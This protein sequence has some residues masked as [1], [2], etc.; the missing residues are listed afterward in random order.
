MHAVDCTSYTMT[1][2]EMHV[3]K[4]TAVQSECYVIPTTH[5][6]RLTM[7]CL[8]VPLNHGGNDIRDSAYSR[9]V[10]SPPYLFILQSVL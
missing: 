2:Y 6:H 4:L 8:Y 5:F 9:S 10:I 3:R 1:L 7:S